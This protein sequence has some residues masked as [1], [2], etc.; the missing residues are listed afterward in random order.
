[1]PTFWLAVLTR[2][3]GQTDPVLAYDWGSL[4]GLCTPNY[5]SLYAAIMICS[6]LVNTQTHTAELTKILT[7]KRQ[8][9][10]EIKRL[11]NLTLG[12]V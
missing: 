5:K 8:S 12:S 2:E 9:Q 1:M 6:S 3:V 10:T 4:V 7:R 11:R